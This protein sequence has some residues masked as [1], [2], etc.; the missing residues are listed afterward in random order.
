MHSVRIHLVHGALPR[1]RPPQAF[2]MLASKTVTENYATVP[3]GLPVLLWPIKLK[4]GT[5]QESFSHKDPQVASAS[6]AIPMAKGI[7]LER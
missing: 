2:C 5:H 6:S 4:E 3:V 7:Q 1:Q